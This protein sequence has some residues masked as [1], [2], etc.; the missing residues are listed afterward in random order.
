MK[1]PVGPNDKFIVE[2]VKETK[3]I[4]EGAMKDI[5]FTYDSEGNTI[6]LEATWHNADAGSWDSETALSVAMEIP[7]SKV[8]SNN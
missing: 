4:I 8:I 3:D 7:G 1:R 5:L 6:A 2:N